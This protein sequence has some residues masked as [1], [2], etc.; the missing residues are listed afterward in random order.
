M[1]QSASHTIYATTTIS[2]VARNQSH[3]GHLF[4]VPCILK[5]TLSQRNESECYRDKEEK[6]HTERET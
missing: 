2:A 5:T 6:R 3:C 4:M 1:S